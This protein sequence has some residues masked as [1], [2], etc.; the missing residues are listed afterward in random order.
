MKRRVFCGVL[1]SVILFCPMTG[2]TREAESNPKKISGEGWISDGTSLG[3]PWWTK[4]PKKL[5]RVP[6]PLL[7]HFELSYSYSNSAGNVDMQAH[8][9]SGHFFL[10]KNV[11]TSETL[12]QKNSQEIAVN[13]LPGA[14]STLVESETAA[15]EFSLALTDVTSLV[16]GAVWLKND[17]AQYVNL[18]QVYYGGLLFT[19][20]DTP[21][22]TF[23]IATS[24]GFMES[25]YL[26]ENIISVYEDF[27]PVDD[28]DS[29][30]LNFNLAF[31]WAIND[32][33]TL[34]ETASYLLALQDSEYYKWSAVTG[35]KCKITDHISF[36][37]KYSV[38][39]HKNP[40]VQEVQDFLEA[41]RAAG[42]LVGEMEEIDT[43]LS[44]GITLEF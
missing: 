25:S 33:I 29:D 15:Q 27:Q 6:N 38:N 35:I 5:K 18:G 13:L 34:T 44:A 22:F 30:A 14:S 43:A 23:N 11:F 20:L 26:N 4:N 3:V 7:Y 16:A 21:E 32:M 10:R 36:F 41:K 17:S 37:T 39:Y 1:I 19:P 40:L 12:F 28:F 9:G 8:N 24:Y 31:S 2:F 42:E